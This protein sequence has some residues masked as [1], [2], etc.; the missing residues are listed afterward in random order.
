NCHLPLAGTA[1]AVR[2]T[3]T[4]VVVLPDTF[5]ASAGTAVWCIGMVV[6]GFLTL[7]L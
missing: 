4:T 7:D 5:L 6:A 2:Y 1:T 3:G